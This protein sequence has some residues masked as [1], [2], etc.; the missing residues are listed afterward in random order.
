MTMRTMSVRDVRQRWP[1]AERALRT[2]RE[3]IVTRDGG[4][5]ARLL[6][7]ADLPLPAVR[8]LDLAELRRW[9]RRFWRSQ[10]PQP[11]TGEWLDHDRAD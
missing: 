1:E 9:R 2:H 6:P 11:P 4:P 8:R 3:I 5:V 10:P 7:L